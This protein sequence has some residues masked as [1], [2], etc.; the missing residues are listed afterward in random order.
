M[1]NFFRSHFDKIGLAIV[2]LPILIIVGVPMTFFI[3]QT[4]E[5][6][7]DLVPSVPLFLKGVQMFLFW[8]MGFLMVL[9]ALTSLKLYR[10]KKQIKKL[11]Q[12]IV[13]DLREKCQ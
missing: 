6:I 1:K 2:S 7:Y 8:L 9:I 12:K 13:N 10:D 3:Y 5:L 11:R 4:T